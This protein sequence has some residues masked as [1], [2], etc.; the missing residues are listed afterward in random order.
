MI[1]RKRKHGDYRGR[2]MSSFT[3]MEVGAWRHLQNTGHTFTYHRS[4]EL[5]IWFAP[6]SDHPFVRDC[7]ISS[8]GDIWFYL[9]IPE[10]PRCLMEVFVPIIYTTVCSFTSF[11]IM[12]MWVSV[13]RCIDNV[14]SDGAHELR[15]IHVSLFFNSNSRFINPTPLLINSIH[16]ISIIRYLGLIILVTW[17]H[18]FPF[19]FFGNILVWTQKCVVQKAS[20]D[21][22]ISYY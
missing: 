2:S 18:S 20:V 11:L 4:D 9:Y 3:C 6:F 15:D 5:C 16:R 13:A 14:C 7:N 19:T 12:V 22:N 17:L 8:S 10:F 21:V 1:A